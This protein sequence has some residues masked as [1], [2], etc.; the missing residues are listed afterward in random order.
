MTKKKNNNSQFYTDWT[1][2]KLK[3]TAL[4]LDSLING[5]SPCYGVRD[6][7]TFDRVMAELAKRGHEAV[8]KLTFN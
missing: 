1:T 6:L 3:E 5:Q 7:I 8:N 4:E 2:K